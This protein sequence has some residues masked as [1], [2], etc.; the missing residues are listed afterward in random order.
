MTDGVVTFDPGTFQSAYPAFREA[1][2]IV[3]TEYFNQACLILNNT[4]QSVVCDLE[5]RATLLNLLTAHIA[6]LA[7]RAAQGGQAGGIVGRINQATQGS[8]S[9]GADL[10]IQQSAAW[11]AQ[12]PYGMTYWAATANLRTFRYNAAPPYVFGPLPW[13]RGGFPWGRGFW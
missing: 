13:S 7:A 9:V 5:R 6:A 1:S 11:Y 12:T 2:P 3:L 10:P 4:P 8:V